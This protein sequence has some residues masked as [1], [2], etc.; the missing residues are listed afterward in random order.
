M[1]KPKIACGPSTSIDSMVNCWALQI[2]VE[3]G[4]HQLVVDE[5]RVEDLI[6]AWA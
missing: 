6:C 2:L 4:V 3:L 5:S 1:D